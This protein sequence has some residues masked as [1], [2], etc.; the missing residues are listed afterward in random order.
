[1]SR[2]QHNIIY[3][4]TPR[5]SF[6]HKIN[7][8]SCR[9]PTQQPQP[10]NFSYPSTATTMRQFSSSTVQVSLFLSIVFLS[11]HHG[12]NTAEAFSPDLPVI[13]QD[14]HHHLPSLIQ[15]ATATIHE[16]LQ[17]HHQSIFSTSAHLASS[18]TSAA[19]NAFHSPQEFL[20]SLYSQYRHTL[21]TKPLPTKIMTGCVLAVAGDAIAQSREPS[22]YNPKRAAS[23]VAFDGCWRAVQVGTYKPL[24]ALCNGQFSMNLVKGLFGSGTLLQQ[25][26]QHLDPY[27]FGAME[28]TLVSQLVL[29]PRKFFLATTN[30]FFRSLPFRSS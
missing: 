19:K 5:N 20:A 26:Q 25:Q 9:K 6:C 12:H 11:C 1:M 27:L 18:T 3:T 21:D 14:V 29:I 23:F 13:L 4:S 17:Q 28:Q 30:V 15:R 8:W 24:V 2:I 22:G 10:I 16:P 7:S